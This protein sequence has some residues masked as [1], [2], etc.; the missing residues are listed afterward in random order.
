M[1]VLIPY[2]IVFICFI[3]A[4]LHSRL[5]AKKL[6]DKMNI[7]V[8][9][10]KI[11][12]NLMEVQVKYIELIEQNK[13]KKFPNINKYLADTYG[14]LE[15]ITI[16]VDFNNIRITSVA[17]D[18]KQIGFMKELNRELDN[19]DDEIKELVI[20]KLNII[21]KI[22]KIKHPF[23]CFWTRVSSRLKINFLI[24]IIKAL[25]LLLDFIDKILM[26]I[27]KEDKENEKEIFNPQ[28]C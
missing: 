12:C 20:R 10:T 21:N 11:Y 15:S 22:A 5:K 27:C 28:I 4:I 7:E 8:E 1:Y 6:I 13:L 18:K 17:K 24:Y 9:K 2:F 16:H 14:I 23:L 25:I 19:V 3:L 26:H